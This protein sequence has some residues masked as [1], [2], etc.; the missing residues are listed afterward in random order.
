[1][2]DDMK[3]DRDERVD[4]SALDPCEDPERF[5]RLVRGIRR[6]ATP[7]LMRRQGALGLWG[8][9]ARWRRPILAASGVLAIA[10]VLVL[11]T[12]RPSSSTRSFAAET[13]GIPAEWAHWIESGDRPG[14]ADLLS[15]EWSER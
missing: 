15:A 4:L 7:E 10:S 1:M 5:E 9:L 14:P 8:E 2:T 6:A 13:L 12:V 3:R 11:A